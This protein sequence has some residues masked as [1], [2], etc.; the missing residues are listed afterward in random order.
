MA[1]LPPSHITIHCSASP[2][3]VYVDAKVLD[4]WHRERGFL[5]IGYH[6]VIKRDGTVEYGRHISEIGAHTQGH[7]T[8]NIGICLVG[9][10][11]ANMKPEQ[12]FT[13]DQYHALAV[14]LNGLKDN[15]PNAEVLGHRDWP[16][17]AK[18]CPSF[19]VRKWIKETGVFAHL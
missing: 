9:G 15:Y 8:G 5:K 16:K 3:N 13:E 12:N 1:N 10:C 14:L 17:V 11:D 18:A 6:F 19:D 2:V 4:R 7:N